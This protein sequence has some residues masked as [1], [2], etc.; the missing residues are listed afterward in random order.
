MAKKERD[1][2]AADEPAVDLNPEIEAE[3]E[4]KSEVRSQET[5]AKATAVPPEAE[6]PKSNRQD[7][8]QPVCPA[9][10]VKCVSK[11]STET[12]TWYYCPQAGCPIGSQGYSEKVLRPFARARMA[13]ANEESPYSAR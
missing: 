5:K 3:Q 13:K 8:P 7:Q 4:E 10:K 9:C 6:G 12:F 1:A 2:N 11:H